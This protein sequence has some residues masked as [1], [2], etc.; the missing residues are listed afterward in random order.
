MV[1]I[2]AAALLALLAGGLLDIAV[3]VSAAVARV[4]PYALAASSSVLFGIVGTFGLA[5]ATSPA[6]RPGQGVRLGLEAILGDGPL[7]FG[8]IGLVVDRLS[9]L[10]L[11]LTV[12]TALLVCL[13]CAGWAARPGRVIH[14]GLGGACCLAL[15]AVALIVTA[16]NVFLFVFA[17]ELL[18]IAFYLLAGFDRANPRHAGDSLITVVFGKISGAAVLLGFLLLAGAAHDFTFTALSSLPRSPLRDAGFALW[19]AGFAVKVGLVP[20]HVWMPRGYQAAPGPLRAIM[21][22]VAVNVGF[23]GMRRTLE[24]LRVPPGCSRSRCC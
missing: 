14:R 10:F 6:A 15:G 5:G 20:T 19:V 3:G 17:W 2:L 23:Y 18:T 22:G 8:P 9:G 7:S 21:A 16:D 12:V 13:A 11:L 24:L 4:V 1:W